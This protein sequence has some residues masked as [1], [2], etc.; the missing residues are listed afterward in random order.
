MISPGLERQK[1]REGLRAKDPDRTNIQD[2]AN[3]ARPAGGS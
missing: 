1:R 2:M 3:E